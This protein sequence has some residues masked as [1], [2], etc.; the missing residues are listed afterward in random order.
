MAEDG[1]GGVAE[2]GVD[3]LA[4]DNA[5]AVEGLAWGFLERLGWRFGGSRL[6]RWV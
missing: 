3:E 1:G 5:V 2:V 4:G 6:A